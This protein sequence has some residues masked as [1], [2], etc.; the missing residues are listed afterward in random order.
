MSPIRKIAFASACAGLVISAPMASARSTSGGVP[1]YSFSA[2]A[3]GNINI[4]E[5]TVSDDGKYIFRTGTQTITQRLAARYIRNPMVSV[6]VV[7]TV[8]N[9]VTVEGAVEQPGVFNFQ[10][11]TTLLG[12]MALAHGPK[13]VA[14]LDQVVIF[15][16]VNGQPLAARFDLNLVRAG[17]MIDPVLA[18][19]DRIVL[20]VSGSSQAWQDLLQALPVFA[21][22]TRI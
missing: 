10:T 21:L 12:A 6:N 15:R 1:A 4:P 2:Q 13:R 14:R 8:S 20:G 18:P 16:E 3:S 22:F 19:N 11:N 5:G 9:I 17:Q 7:S